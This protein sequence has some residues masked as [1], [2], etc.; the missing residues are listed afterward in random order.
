MLLVILLLIE[1]GLESFDLVKS[2]EFISIDEV[3]LLLLQID[4]SSDAISV[5]AGRKERSL[6]ELRMIFVHV[7]AS[8]NSMTLFCNSEILEICSA[9]QW[10]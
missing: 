10:R 7:H 3:Q 4:L 9:R 8:N 1:F 5:S 2:V 6:V